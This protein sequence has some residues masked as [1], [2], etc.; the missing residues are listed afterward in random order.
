[1]F[2]SRRFPSGVIP[3]HWHICDTS[4]AMSGKSDDALGLS[5]QPPGTF[6]LRDEVGGG[7]AQP[8]C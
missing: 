6:G 7:G 2:T 8:L 1:M 5:E 4:P 3:E